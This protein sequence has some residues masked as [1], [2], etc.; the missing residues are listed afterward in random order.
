VA[1]GP[2]VDLIDHDVLY[3]FYDPGSIA[4]GRAYADEGRAALLDGRPGTIAAVCRGSGRASY[5]V[6]ISWTVKNGEVV[7]LSDECTCPLGGA[8]KHCVAA[9]LTALRRRDRVAA[10]PSAASP[11]SRRPSDDWRRLLDALPS[12][13]ATH[14]ASPV[15][16]AVLIEVEQPRP[17]RFS[18]GDPSL[19]VRP[20]KAGRKGRWVKS[21]AAWHEVVAPYHAVDDADPRHLAA[22]RSLATSAGLTPYSRRVATVSLDEFD[23]SLWDGLDRALDIGVTLVGPN[24]E[25]YVELVADPA[26]VEIDLTSGDGGDAVLSA[27]LVLGDERLDLSPIPTE[28]DGRPHLGSWPGRSA[29]VLWRRGGF[30]PDGRGAGTIGD[31][32]HGV[33]LVDGGRMRLIRLAEPVPAPISR[34]LTS[35][36]VPVPATDVDEVIDVYEPALSRHGRIGSSDG[37]VALTAS[38]FAGLVLDVNRPA[39][40]I[41]ELRWRARY[42]RGDRVTDHPLGVPARAGRDLDAEADAV[43][44]LELPAV[45]DRGGPVDTVV[46]GATAVAVLTD[47]IPWLESRGQVT[48]EVRGDVPDLTEAVD[49]PLVSLAVTDAADDRDGNDWF[50]LR[51]LVEVDGQVVDFAS[52]FAALDRGDELMILPSGTW[53]RLDQPE[54]VRLRELIEEARGLAEPDGDA[55]A[56]LNRFQTDWWDE[57]ASLGVVTEQ[58]QRW[59]EQVARMSTLA[60][61][62][63]VAPPA[64]LAATLRPYQQEGLDWLAFLHANGLG[65]I[66]ADDMGL[67]KTVQTLALCLHILESR[68]DARFLVVAPTSVVEN[69]AREAERFAPGVPVRTIRETEARRGVPL[70]D[71]IGHAS[72]V[73]TSYALFRLEFDAYAEHDWELLLLDEAQFVKNH[74]GKTHHCVRRLDAASKIAITGTPL[75]N[76]L[77]DLWSLL[78]I[79][80][81]GLYPDPKRFSETYRKPIEAGSAPQLLATLRRRIAPLMRRRTKDAVLT[82]LP[83]KTEQVVEVPMSSRHARIYGTQLQRQRQKILGLVDDVDRNRFE[84]LKSLTLLRQLALDPGL[85]DDA[86]DG[87]GSAKLDRLVEDLTQIVAEGHRALV[88]SQFTRYLARVRTRLDTAGIGYSYLDGRTRRRDEAI[89]R[90]KDGDAPVFVISLKAGG[91][92]LNL[93]EA[94]YCFVL[95]PWWNP[96]TEV[97]AVDRAHRIGQRNPVMVYRYVSTDTIEEKVMELKDRKAKLFARVMDSEGGALSGAI[98]AD[99][100]RGLLDLG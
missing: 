72:I 5:L 63:P 26:R 47:A 58:S 82:D 34:L 77:M 1:P 54:L 84:I 85:V 44:A 78:S 70:A 6:D 50:D 28:L 98:T 80:A 79:T 33:W 57:L 14:R 71:A 46:S 100:I 81:P 42:R 21:G 95:D 90:F 86:D 27:V 40:D 96:A 89:A 41:A 37:S 91:F 45:L 53:L 48:V 38:E 75:E 93:T 61:P 76:T 66:L 73:V 29:P 9:I 49:A 60:E 74:Q 12:D 55:D 36:G 22:V 62:E 4:R 64:G 15:A 51:V 52:L 69:W 92:G 39:L 68:P 16:L 24:S 83:P 32:V 94:D 59:A 3:E 35:G 20:L 25:T 97:Q 87:V 30:A 88:F 56:R 11:A 8:C 2:T 10:A 17:S 13:D 65:G 7:G 67:G 99:D 31:P 19:V 18:A 23:P 43:A